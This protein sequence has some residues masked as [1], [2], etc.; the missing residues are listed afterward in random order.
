MLRFTKLQV[1]ALLSVFVGMRFRWCF[2]VNGSV[3]VH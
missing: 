3:N 2:S 1:H